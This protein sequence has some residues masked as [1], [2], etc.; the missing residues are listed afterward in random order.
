MVC[1]P[2]P[3]AEVRH[4]MVCFNVWRCLVATAVGRLERRA[5]MRQKVHSEFFYKYGHA[6]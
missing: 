3:V 6:N 2:E 4:L 1:Q 5:K